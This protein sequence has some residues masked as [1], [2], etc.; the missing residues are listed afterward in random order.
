MGVVRL[1]STITLVGLGPGDPGMISIAAVEAL[2]GSNQVWLRTGVHPVVDWLK[3]KGIKY[4]TFDRVYQECENFQQVYKKIA[5]EVIE[6]GQSSD[7]VYALPGHP[8]MAEESVDLIIKEVEDKG[9]KIKIIPGVSFLDA[10]VVALRL[11]PVAG[12][13]ILDGLRVQSGDLQP[14]IGTVLVQAYN[15]IVLSD[16]KLTLME[17][18]PDEHPVAVVTA[19]G[20]PGEEKLE[21]CL[22]YELDRVETVNHLTSIYIPPVKTP[23]PFIH[24]SGYPLDPLVNVMKTLR[25]SKGC[26]WDREQTHDTLKKYL[27]EETYELLEALERQDMYNICEELGDLLLQIVFHSQI[28]SESGNFDINDV[29]GAIVEK[30][31]RRHPHV[32]R[33]VKVENSDDVIVNWEAIK[34]TEK[35]ANETKSILDGVPKSFP[36][37]MK[38]QKVQSKASKVGFDWEDYRGA[39]AKVYEELAEIQE[40]IESNDWRQKESEIGDALFAMVNLA[41]LLNID[42]EVALAGTIDKFKNRFFYIEEKAAK[43]RR[44]LEE[45]DMKKMDDWWEEAKKGE[46]Q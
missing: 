46:K 39:L 30:M 45:V 36:S 29:V 8:L 26:P 16:I 10:L 27:L 41:R 34:K 42:A 1:G 2:A 4:R 15:K 6:L 28:A 35:Q 17:V 22:L 24:Q 12:L 21:H 37:L 19:A 43:N 18:Y 13:T 23:L 32:F 20:V 5:Q 9:L 38:A 3:G 33:N 25:G 31:I 11:D 40:A 44:K 7:V 14:G